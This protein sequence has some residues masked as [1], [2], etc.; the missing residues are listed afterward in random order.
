MAHARVGRWGK[1][2]AVRL[3]TQVATSLG[4]QEGD[5]V[6]VLTREGEAVVRRLE[7]AL[8]AESLFEGRSSDEWRAFYEDCYDWG[9]DIG[10][11]I[12]DE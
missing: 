12:V 6:E 7:P 2:L 4:L 8:T 9:P 5:R 10:R 11:E 1:S 3:P